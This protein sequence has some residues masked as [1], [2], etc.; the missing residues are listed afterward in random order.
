MCSDLIVSIW[1]TRS[2]WYNILTCE[3]GFSSI[4]SAKPHYMFL[5][6]YNDSVFDKKDVHYKLGGFSVYSIA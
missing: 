5:Y 2:E 4:K 3:L 1:S 6:L